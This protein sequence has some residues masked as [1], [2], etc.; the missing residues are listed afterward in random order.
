MPVV[1][2]DALCCCEGCSKRFGVELEL[3]TNLQENPDI[4]PDFEALAREAIRG[5]QSNCYVWGVR[6]KATVDRLPL[7]CNPTIQ[8][9]FMLCDLCT[10]KCD[11]LP[12]KGNLTKEQVM[13]VLG[14][15]S[16]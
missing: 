1:R 6:G 13:A 7:T 12:I 15:P 16:E 4:F 9:D 10:T 5:G 3:A 14:M 8:G 11:N 2:I